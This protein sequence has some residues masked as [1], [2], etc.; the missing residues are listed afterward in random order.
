MIAEPSALPHISGPT[1][2]FLLLS[3]PPL[4]QTLF[5]ARNREKGRITLTNPYR[6][7]ISLFYH[8]V[9]TH[10][11]IPPR[12]SVWKARVN[13]PWQVPAWGWLND[14]IQR[15]NGQLCIPQE[16]HHLSESASA[17]ACFRFP[18]FTQAP[19]QFTEWW[20]SVGGSICGAGHLGNGLCIV[21]QGESHMS[22]LSTDPSLV[23][24]VHL[25]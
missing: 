5:S 1:Q 12:R 4:A 16:F 17:L 3:F 14:C 2:V 21:L 7:V 22:Q 8:S 15:L 10:P 24:R 20:D 19:V 6:D 13:V 25:I 18:G 11:P 23:C 9:F